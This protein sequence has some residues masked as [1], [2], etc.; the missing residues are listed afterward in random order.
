MAEATIGVTWRGALQLVRRA[1]HNEKL[2][3]QRGNASRQ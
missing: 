3:H 2:H 1:A